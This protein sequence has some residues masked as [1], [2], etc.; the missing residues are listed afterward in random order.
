MKGTFLAILIMAASTW[1]QTSYPPPV[2]GRQSAPPPAAAPTSNPAATAAA[3]VA[4]QV[5]TNQLLARLGQT[6]SALNTSLAGLR[7]EKWKTS[8]QDKAQLQSN[9]DSIRRNLNR[10]LPGIMQDVR[11]APNNLG[12][13]FK[14]YRNVGALY[15]VLASLTEAAG[16]FGPQQEFRD[17]SQQLQQLD[18][19][20]HDLGDR[21]EQLSSTKDAE[22]VRLGAQLKQAQA[23]IPPKKVVVDDT[24]DKPKPK[25][26]KKPSATTAQSNDKPQQQ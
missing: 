19:L 26:K 4:P 23:A 25:K 17:L 8:G 3:A 1:G 13:T 7:I 9:A 12:P 15:D 21:M 5:D 2:P 14:L 24:E 11:N 16:A 22:I 18:T 6:G 10:A 20:R